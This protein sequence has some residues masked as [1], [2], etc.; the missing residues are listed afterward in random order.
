MLPGVR[1][2]RAI[3]TYAGVRPTLYTYGPNEDA[4][5]RDHAVVDHASDGAPGVY[6]MIGGKLASFRLFAQE[7]CDITSSRDFDLAVPCST[8]TRPLP[9]G[10]GVPDAIRL[11]EEHEVTPVA[12]RRLVYRHGARA[13]R[14][15]ERLAVSPRERDVT[16]PCEPV[17]EAEVRHV[18]HAELARTVDDVSRRTR[19]G[20]GACGGMRCAAR[21][22]QIVAEEQGLPPS[23]ARA[24]A[25]DF[26][27]RQARA[28]V[29]AMGPVQARQEV[30]S[31]AHARA[32][33]GLRR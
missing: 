30:L 8:H 20:L 16:C 24:L 10:E 32:S 1:A 33:L 15:L 19:L 3:G 31:L 2:A 23:Q 13:I 22:G 17:L 5:S 26:L 6:S 12:A 11:A 28:R 7:L 29:V 21:C 18:L 9:G 27:E 4:L 14:I 25:L